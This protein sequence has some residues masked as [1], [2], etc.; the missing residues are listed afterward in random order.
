LSSQPGPAKLHK[1]FEQSNTFFS[2]SSFSAHDHGEL[3]F[4]YFETEQPSFRPPLFE[5]IKE[6]SSLN[7]SG[8]SEKLQNLKLSDLHPASWYCVAWYPVYRVPHGNFR[9]SFLTYHSLG[10]LVPQSGGQHTSIVCPVVG[11]QGYND[12]GEQWSELKCPD[13]LK[14]RGA[15]VVNEKLTALRRGALALARAVTPRGSEESSANH[16]PDYEFFLSRST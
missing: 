6:L 12:K 10:K 14:P 9:A 11:L 1:P 7:P 16:H 2:E 3:V 13:S 5:K 4:E 8:D 15:E